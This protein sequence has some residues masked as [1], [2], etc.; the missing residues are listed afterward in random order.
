MSLLP[1]E[2]A[3]AR[4]LEGAF[5]VADTE[6]VGLRHAQGRILA[7]A[8]VALRTQPGFDASAMDGYA[9]RA[10]DVV[11]G[12]PLRVVGAVQAGH[13]APP[14]GAGEVIRIFTGAPVPAG[15][16]AVLIQENC[17]TDGHAMIPAATVVAGENIR[18]SGNDFAAGDTLIAAGAP[19]RAA[20][21]ALAGSGGHAELP[22]LR[23]PRVSILMTGDELVLPGMSAGPAQIVASNGYAVAAIVEAA[24]GTVLGVDLAPDDEALIAGRLEAAEQAGADVFVTIGGASVGE[25]DLVEG[26]LAKAGVVLH[27]SKVAIRP[28]KPVLAGRRGSFRA[29][30]LPG[31]PASSL[32]AAT[33]FLRP[34]VERLAGRVDRLTMYPGVLGA[35]LPANDQRA[36]FMRARIEH[37][38]GATRPTV[39]PLG[40]QDS[41]LM[42]V[43]AGADV[44]LFRPANAAPAFTGDLCNFVPLD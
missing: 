6:S 28:G 30:G 32:V 33:L 4:L 26:V 18:P 41:S 29:I 24:G 21:I 16:D 40:R 20:R 25:Y 14:L 2:D 35:D 38:E 10:A 8:I 43:I 5:A 22:V 19:L 39:R 44:L 34:L 36:E 9:V 13:S 1:F 3:L 7:E 12:R 17:R 31:N 42:S 15:A 11:V 23:R 37:I 27:F